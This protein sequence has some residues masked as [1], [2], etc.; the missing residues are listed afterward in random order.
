MR[1][2]LLFPR[3]LLGF[4]NFDVVFLWIPIS[5]IFAQCVK[6]HLVYLRAIFCSI[7]SK[8]LSG[9]A[10]DMYFQQIQITAQPAYIGERFKKG[11]AMSKTKCT[12]FKALPVK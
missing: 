8:K 5:K 2:E 9:G 11:F 1:P 4:L 12:P 3:C 7:F 6:N 10:L